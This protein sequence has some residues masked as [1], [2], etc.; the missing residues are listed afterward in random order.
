[1]LY[2]I[3]QVSIVETYFAE[4]SIM[5]N[6]TQHTYIPPTVNRTNEPRIT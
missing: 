1:M 5:T 6:Q 3:T 4:Y 2:H